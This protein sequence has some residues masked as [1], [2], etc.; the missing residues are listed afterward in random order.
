MALIMEA[1]EPTVMHEGTFD[2]LK[3]LAQ[4]TYLDLDGQ[5]NT[6]LTPHELHC[7]TI[8]KGC[9]DPRER[10][11]VESHVE[12][13]YRFL[14]QIPW[15]KDLQGI[16]LIAY[17]HHEKL[18]GSGYPRRVREQDIPIQTRMMTIADIFDALTA[19]D[20]PYKRAVSVE[21]ALDIMRDEV[22]GQMLDHHLFNIFVEA[23]VYEQLP[24]KPSESISTK[25]TSCDCSPSATST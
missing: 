17:G 11:E 22:E 21:R 8:R 20:R 2:E 7:L 24:P 1:N 6:L 5:P 10:E 25:T 12:H 3:S 15:T 18:N 13:T 14:Q 9:L 19:S 4:S 23:R 16:P